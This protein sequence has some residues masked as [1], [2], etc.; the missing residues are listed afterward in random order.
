MQK[1]RTGT[2]GTRGG[3][4]GDSDGPVVRWSVIDSPV[5]PLFAAVSDGAVV[6]LGF[7][8]DDDPSPAD[9]WLRDDAACDELRSQLEEYF[10]GERH[11]F[12]LPLA[13]QGTEFQMAVWT[14]LRD[15]PYGTTASYG[16]I[17]AAVGRPKAVRAVG[18]ANNANPISIIVPCHRVIGADGNLTGYGGGLGTKEALLA[19]ES[20]G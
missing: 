9:G 15:I 20:G 16:D 7:L 3:A 11:E 12:D 17:A 5:G 8:G 2:R 18:G 1:T 4:R 19:L 10:A 13:P 14:A 6:E